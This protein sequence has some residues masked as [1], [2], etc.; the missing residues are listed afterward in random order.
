[1]TVS[2]AT[3]AVSTRIRRR[4][5]ESYRQHA[6]VHLFYG[7]EKLVEADGVGTRCGADRHSA[8]ISRAMKLLLNLTSF[9]AIIGMAMPAHADSTDDAIH[10][11][12]ERGRHHLL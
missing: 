12:T 6:G 9:A 10:F 3:A 5:R 2:A 1:M 4:I 7:V 8:T 11:R